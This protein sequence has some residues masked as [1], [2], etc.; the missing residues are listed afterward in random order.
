MDVL[1][2][3][4][5]LTHG[6]YAATVHITDDDGGTGTMSVDISVLRSIGVS[7]PA[8]PSNLSA[9]V[10]STTQVDLAWTDNAENE[11][12]FIISASTDGGR[13]FTQLTTTAMNGTAA[14]LTN[15][16]PGTSY[17]FGVTAQNTT[18]SSSTGTGSSTGATLQ[19]D[20]VTITG[21]AAVEAGIPYTVSLSSNVPADSWT[22]DWG[23][24]TETLTGSQ[25]TA[26]HTYPLPND[27]LFVSASVTGSAGTFYSRGYFLEVAPATAPSSPSN[28]TATAASTSQ[29]NLSWADAASN[30]Q[31]YV[32][33]G[34][35]ETYNGSYNWAQIATVGP[36]QGG[37]GSYQVTGLN[38]SFSSLGVKHY[39]FR[40]RSYR[41]AAHSNYSSVAESLALG[42]GSQAPTAPTNLIGLSPFEGSIDVQGD[43]TSSN[44]LGFELEVRK[45]TGELHSYTSFAGPTTGPNFLYLGTKDYEAGVS[46]DLKVRA[47]TGGGYSAPTN[48]VSWQ[49]D[50]ASPLAPSDL[51]IVSDSLTSNEV[52][53]EWTPVSNDPN[54]TNTFL[55]MST[56][57][58]NFTQVS[59]NT[60][61]A[62]PISR[63][64]GLTPDTP[65][66]FRLRGL[67]I[68]G[69]L[70]DFSN[71]VTTTTPAKDVDLELA[72][73]IIV[74]NNND[75]NGVPGID[76]GQSSSSDPD[77]TAL[78]IELMPHIQSG[79]VTLSV[80]STSRVNVWY[81]GNKIIGDGDTWEEWE[82]GE[83]PESVWVE[84]LAASESIGDVAFTLSAE[85]TAAVLGAPEAA[86]QPAT[87]SLSIL[88]LKLIFLPGNTPITNLEREIMVGERVILAAAA[89]GPGKVLQ[90]ASYDWDIPGNIVGDYEQK[91]GGSRL[92][93]FTGD[94]KQVAEY[95]WIDGGLN[96]DVSCTFTINGETYTS[97]T[98]FDV[99]R[100]EYG[101]TAITTSNEP[102]IQID[103]QELAGLHEMAFGA[104]E[105]S[106]GITFDGW[107]QN[108]VNRKGRIQLVQIIPFLR[109]TAT[110]NDDHIATITSGQNRTLLD[111]GN[112]QT[113]VHLGSV[114][115]LPELGANVVHHVDAPN[116]FLTQTIKEQFVVDEFQ[117]FLMYKSDEEGS[118][119]VTLAKVDWSWFGW[120]VKGAE[121]WSVIDQDSSEHP[122]FADSI[123]LPQWITFASMDN[124]VKIGL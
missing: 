96:R 42:D 67:N 116:A 110:F 30:E 59:Q 32:I 101:A 84:G 51:S 23:D 65:Y 45:S 6:L 43:D 16:A 83:Q 91:L 72:D 8:A 50:S 41:G 112:N 90:K 34:A 123:Q 121:G 17:I 36:V 95:R 54:G 60:V 93:A 71:T 80:N 85:P 114:S 77:W 5:Y 25:T 79:T 107:A 40:V 70:F 75:N 21:P 92:T 15:L 56:D 122:P 74:A 31:G 100:P 29:I 115:E 3:R 55:E 4:Q 113:T 120:A 1:A 118:V 61:G 76:L 53:L 49:F 64:T 18:G 68:F 22:I 10:L 124:Y 119:W 7:I 99:L 73:R 62:E 2:H 26:T 52:T 14:S 37:Q 58:V 98:R 57:G 104:L 103:F 9:T 11:D 19:G 89:Y 117:T 78:Q 46:Y 47:Y 106:P 44:E 39:Y 97:T 82:V 109:H 108:P 69:A 86:T 102:P 20:S 27:D 48:T 33:E 105:G 87:T 38:P 35:T 88:E 63:V 24:S 28:L 13:T 94:K 66:Y 111:A 81:N 12:E